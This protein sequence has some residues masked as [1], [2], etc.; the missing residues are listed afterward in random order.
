MNKLKL[1]KAAVFILTFL[2][3][4]GTL[5]F[6]GLLYQKTH[7]SAQPLPAGLSLKQPAGS[8]IKQFSQENGKLYLLV[9]GGGEED[10]IVIFDSNDGKTLTTINLD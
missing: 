9:I 3:V 4:F 5:S 6:L 7:K 8:Y 10:R 2:L 1:I